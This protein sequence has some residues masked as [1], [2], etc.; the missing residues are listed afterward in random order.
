VKTS[1]LR[2]ILSIEATCEDRRD[3]FRD[4]LIAE[5][6][7]R[8]AALRSDA[9][10][11][12]S[13]LMYH[14]TTKCINNGNLISFYRTCMCY[15]LLTRYRE[16]IRRFARCPSEFQ[17]EFSIADRLGTRCSRLLAVSDRLLFRIT[18]GT[19]SR[20]ASHEVSARRILS[21]LIHRR[22]CGKRQKTS[23]IDR[24]R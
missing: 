9:M 1:V 6:I 11:F 16:L 19:R 12:V 5:Q 23:S 17:G 2:R 21:L 24:S 4:I 10:L 18:R 22:E 15:L 7:Q 3:P 13:L 14:R 20:E 8:A